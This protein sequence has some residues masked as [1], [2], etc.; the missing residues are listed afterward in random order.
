MLFMDEVKDVAE[1]AQHHTAQLLV[2]GIWREPAAA[3]RQLMLYS[4]AVSLTWLLGRGIN[5]HGGWQFTSSAKRRRS[6]AAQSK[7]NVRSFHG[8]L[9]GWHA[10]VFDRAG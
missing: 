8:S 1:S 10:D 5:Q 6:S 4:N 3:A 7:C 2:I 9:T